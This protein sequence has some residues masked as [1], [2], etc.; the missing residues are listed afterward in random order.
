[1][2]TSIEQAVEVLAPSLEICM[3]THIKNALIEKLQFS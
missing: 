2:E 1:M 3:G